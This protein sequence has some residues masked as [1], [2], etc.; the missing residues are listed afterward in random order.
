MLN[1][2]TLKLPARNRHTTTQDSPCFTGSEQGPG[3]PVDPIEP[4]QRPGDP[5]GPDHGP[6]DPVE[7]VHHVRYPLLKAFWREAAPAPA[8]VSVSTVRRRP[9]AIESNRN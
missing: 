2:T 4:D 6:G 7:P 3:D 5:I 1:R 9:K 8:S